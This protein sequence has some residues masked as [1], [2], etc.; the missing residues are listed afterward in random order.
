MELAGRTALVTG[1]TADGMGRST[2]FTLAK[3]G[4][5]IVLNYGT[6]RKDAEADA[7][8]ARV[9]KAIRELGRR[10]L[11]VKADTRRED[12]VRGMVEQAE[13][14]FGAIDVLVNNASSAWDPRDYT[15]ISFDHWKEALAGQIDG[16][17]LTMKYIVPGMRRRG[18][19]RVVHIGMAGVLRMESAAGVAPDYC[20]GK[21]ARAWMT[22]AFGLQELGNGITVNCIE[23]GIT[24][25][26]TFQDAL[27]A[28]KGDYSKWKDRQ[29]AV[30]HDV[31]EIIRFLCSEAGRFVS[32]ST[33]SLPT[34]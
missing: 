6:N 31:A 25:H 24:A 23:P 10:V 32:G 5:D 3:A 21:A 9:E 34:P 16:A 22:T 15:E 27:E 26:M 28:A 18:W 20:L 1:S 14:Q 8:S 17:F 29:G 30:A 12:D 4:A 11:L 13:D 2:A 33:I 19:G 7:A